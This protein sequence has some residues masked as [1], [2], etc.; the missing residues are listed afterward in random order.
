M[1]QRLPGLNAHL[2]PEPGLRPTRQRASGRVGVQ[3][4]LVAAGCFLLGAAAAAVWFRGSA[5]HGVASR[6]NEVSSQAQGTM[7]EATKAILS[8]LTAPVEVRFYSVI[9]PG[10][11]NDWLRSFAGRVDQMLRAYQEAAADKLKIVRF[12]SEVYSNAS[13]AAADGIKASNA[14]N[15]NT[16]FLGIAV[17]Q[18]ARKQTLSQLAPE[19]ETALEADLSRAIAQVSEPAAAETPAS[20][21]PTSPAV[22][23]E[24]KRLLPNFSSVSVEDGARIL[25]ETALKQFKDAATESQNQLQQA[26]QALVQAQATGSAAEQQAAMKQLQQVQAEQT[27]RL[28]QI[29][30]NSQAQIEALRRLKA[31]SSP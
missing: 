2:A 12:G 13:A 16:S 11:A 19:W 10:A 15:G 4:L 22:V 30:A 17:V 9:E 28:K 7:S 21:A 14:Q 31:G 6:T 24:V 20:A 5:D 18:G 29:A 27:E 3:T 25:R 1:R 8:H 23:E 26:Q